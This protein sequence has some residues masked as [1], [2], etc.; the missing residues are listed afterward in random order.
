MNY[1]F[2]DTANLDEIKEAHDMGIIQGVTTNQSIIAK[3]PTGSFDA[4]IQKLAEYCGSEELSLSVEVFAEGYEPMVKQACEIYEKFSPVCP[5]LYVKIPVGF[6][7]LRAIKKCSN[8]GVK[9][10][11]TICYSEQQL[12]HCASAG[13]KYVSLFY[14]RL[15][16]HGGDVERA[17]R[18]T[19]QY[20]RENGLDTQIIAGSIRTQQDVCDAWDYG[21]DIVTTG[22]PVMKEMV[23]HPK[24][25][26]SYDGFMSDFA[27][28]IN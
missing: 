28:W 18:R 16:Q 9:I 22:L 20:I 7:E 27:A 6:D 12:I 10:N 17:L 23:R 2:A 15:K 11:A 21:A 3:E 25:T 1:L 5:D 8:L 14:C 19:K 13:A 4:L 24:T 26:E